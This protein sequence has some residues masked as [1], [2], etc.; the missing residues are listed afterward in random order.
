MPVKAP[1]RSWAPASP[2]H[3]ARQQAAENDCCL[4]VAASAAYWL[5]AGEHTKNV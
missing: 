1:W 2:L 5:W 3:S 4:P